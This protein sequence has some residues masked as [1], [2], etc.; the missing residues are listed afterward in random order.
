MTLKLPSNEQTRLLIADFIREEPGGKLSV[1]GFYPGNSIVVDEAAS[2]P[3]I[4]Q[5]VS[6]LLWIA[7]GEGELD[8]K[9]LLYAPDDNLIV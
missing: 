3:L 5:S 9:V 2:L 6:L 1:L 7:D 4:L 8:C